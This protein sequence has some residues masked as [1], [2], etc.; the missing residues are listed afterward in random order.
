[1]KQRK[2]TVG[3]ILLC[4]MSLLAAVG[5][6]GCGG[7]G[8]AT[9]QPATATAA[10]TAAA[11][12]PATEATTATSPPTAASTVATEPGV[13][14]T[15]VFPYRVI[16]SGPAQ[17]HSGDEVTYDIQYECVSQLAKTCKPGGVGIVVEW[18]PADATYVSSDPPS[19]DSGAKGKYATFPLAGPGGIIHLTINVSAGFTGPLW[20]QLGPPG[21]PFTVPEGSVG[22]VVTT[23]LDAPTP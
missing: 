9:A 3:V 14:P 5:A 8:H 19:T 15:A 22:E 2:R 18:P 4:L 23:V 6:A 13:M 21:R 20:V 16:L 12:P 17:A 7:S 1:M 11:S 10:A